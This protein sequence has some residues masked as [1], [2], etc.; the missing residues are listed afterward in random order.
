MTPAS[1]SV[2]SGQA[3][4]FTATVTNTSATGEKPTG[5]VMFEDNGVQFG[6]TVNL[7]RWSRQQ[8]HGHQRQH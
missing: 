2:V 5:T 7:R 8:H 1:P 4:R 3:I 6:P